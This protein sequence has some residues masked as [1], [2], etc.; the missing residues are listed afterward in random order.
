MN[1]FRVDN[2]RIGIVTGLL[3]TSLTICLVSGCAEGPLWRT[4]YLSPWARS[5]WANE[6]KI[7]ETWFV[8]R[9]QL[10]SEVEQA[11][12]GGAQAQ[13]Q[14]AKKVDEYYS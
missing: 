4:G 10:E 8:R 2:F 12:A 6:E 1:K 9:K 11:I 7:A 3:V 14:M 13:E 5:H